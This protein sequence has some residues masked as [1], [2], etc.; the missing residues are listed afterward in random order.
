MAVYAIKPE[1][2]FATRK[3]LRRTPFTEATKRMVA[4]VESHDF[5]VRIDEKT[6]EL[7]C[8]VTEKP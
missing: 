8:I 6:K 7:T 3:K 4:F 2:P 1:T 5:F